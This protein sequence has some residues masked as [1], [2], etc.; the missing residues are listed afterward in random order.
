MTVSEQHQH[1]PGANLDQAR[2]WL[3]T[4][5]AGA[6]GLL[7]V[8]ATGAWV[9][10][11]FATDEPGINAAVAY[12]N[13]L[14]QQGKQGIYMRVT[15]LR[16]VPAPGSRGH[17]SDSLSWPGFWA[18]IDLAGPGHKTKH[19]LPPD[20]DTARQIVTAAGLPEPTMW[21]H[22]GGGLYPWWLL[23]QPHTITADDLDDIATLTARW[24]H[25]VKAGSE[26]LG[27]HYGS[28]V[29][30][31]ARVLRIPGTINRK[32]GLA[33]PCVVLEA[34]G[35]TYQ[36]DEL[37]ALLYTIDL[38]DPTPAARQQPPTRPLPTTHTPSQVGPFDALAEACAWADLFEPQGLSYVGSERDGAELWRRDGASSLYSVRAW[39]HVCVNHSENLDL[40]VG[41]GNKLTHGKVFAWWHHRGDHQAAARDL[42]A[43]AAG[44]PDATPAAR[45]LPPAVLD[46]IRQRCG[47]RPWQPP[48]T[49]PSADDAPWPTTP[50]DEPT[51]TAIPA[52]PNTA[53]DD[54]RRALANAD[55]PDILRGL[56]PDRNHIDGHTWTV[57]GDHEGD[58]QHTVL[59]PFPVHTLPGDTGK[60]AEAVAIYM[61]VPVDLPAFAILGA[62]ATLA[63]GHATIRGKWRENALNLFLAAI[64]DSG[65]G[66]SPAVGAV[67]EPIRQ[68]ERVLRAEW[69]NRYGEMADH[70]EIAV[71]TR[72]KLIAKIADTAG[73]KRNNLLADLDSIKQEIADTTPPPRPQL[74]AGDVTPE[75]LG[76]IMNRTGGHI[77]IISAEGGFLGNLTG[78]YSKGQ[79]NLELVLTAFDSSEPY[80]LERITREPFEVD[81][82]SLTLSL[83][84]QP[85]V[86]DDAV[87][88][89]AV[90]DRG[91]LNRFLI[92]R[93]DSLAGRRDKNPPDVPRHLEEAWHSTVH[94]VFRAVLPDGR[95]FDDDG[96]Q[97]D[98]IPMQISETAEDLHLAWRQQ[99]ETRV[100]P[101]SGDLAPIKGWAKK[102]EG[103][104]YRLAALLHLAAGRAAEEPVGDLVML[105]AL[106]IADWAIPHALAV[107]GSRGGDGA[108]RGPADEAAEHVLQWIRRKGVPEFTVDEAR[109]GLRGR[110]WV[111]QHGAT[112][113]RAALVGLARQGWVASVERRGADGRR[114]SE[115]SFVP[116]PQLLGRVL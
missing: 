33:R 65:E 92:A 56:Y 10:E 27:Y 104:V 111:K 106:T 78:R 24:Q 72:D 6:P 70:H 45:N 34:S 99:M 35:V 40:P 7:N 68:L 14:D 32:E 41:A 81:R 98:P 107:L 42:R 8:C 31:L 29:G 51:T 115:G 83:A 100:D 112:G 18:D 102:L 60:F 64:A 87:N 19:Q 15:T 63:G 47:V 69:K 49:P 62:L 67:T 12:I 74:L 36:L 44:N 79:P 114:L 103:L 55:E 108:R 52:S 16:N 26:Q 94:R 21:I 48:P 25:A 54:I 61:Q 1:H 75:V 4:L 105:D 11:Y 57:P 28:G 84:V 97:L 39:P 37:A 73:P 43:A 76:K 2:A 89:A 59:P 80:R 86:I 101:D 85:V 46:H 71:K 53:D 96:N 5:H 95:P 88:S 77:A 3:A 23:D 109:A 20:I 113:V 110:S 116:H 82:P 22:S 91:L 17:A 58:Q 9:G 13:R 90:A 50:T 38:P 30:D 93:P 66:K